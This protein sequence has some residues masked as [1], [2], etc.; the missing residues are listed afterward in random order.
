VRLYIKKLKLKLAVLLQCN[1]HE[2]CCLCKICFQDLIGFVN[3]STSLHTKF[4]AV[5]NLEKG[6]FLHALENWVN[7]LVLQEGNLRLMF[8]IKKDKI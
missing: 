8:S 2:T 6:Q 4:A 5:T 7:F 1:T 3:I